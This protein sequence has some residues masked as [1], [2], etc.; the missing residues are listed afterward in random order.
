MAQRRR[1]TRSVT[2]SRKR[3]SE[4]KAESVT[5]RLNRTGLETDQPSMAVP[6]VIIWRVIVPMN[7]R[8]MDVEIGVG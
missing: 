1:R 3:S 4:Q 5:L 6:M 2:R 8:L 7:G